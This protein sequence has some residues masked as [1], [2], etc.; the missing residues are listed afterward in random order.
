[1]NGVDLTA[2][3]L[4][5]MESVFSKGNSATRTIE[6]NPDF[7]LYVNEEHHDE[8][9]VSVYLESGF[10]L[11][12]HYTFGWTERMK[13]NKVSVILLNSR[14]IQEF[15]AIAARINERKEMKSSDYF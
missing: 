11:P 10:L 9:A 4:A 2:A 14:M 5:S 7:L 15:E 8:M 1:M 3:E 6:G 12:A 13:G